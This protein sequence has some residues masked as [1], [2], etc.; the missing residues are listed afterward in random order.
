MEVANGAHV[1]YDTANITFFT[2][3]IMCTE[4]HVAQSSCDVC[5]TGKVNGF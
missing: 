1:G 5:L 3:Y 4:I 2:K